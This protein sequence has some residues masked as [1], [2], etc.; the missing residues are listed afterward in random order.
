MQCLRKPEV[1][2][3]IVNILLHFG[4]GDDLSHSIDRSQLAGLCCDLQFRA[5]V[6]WLVFRGLFA[7]VA[8][9]GKEASSTTV[10]P[11]DDGSRVTTMRL[12]KRCELHA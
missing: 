1:Y 3:Q 2:R 9:Q 8:S 4:Y 12:T 10:H 6:L 11:G 7:R 5:C